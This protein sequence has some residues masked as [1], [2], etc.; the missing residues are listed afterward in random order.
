[1]VL[2]LFTSLFYLITAEK[3]SEI[4]E[5]TLTLALCYELQELDTGFEIYSANENNLE[6]CN[7]FLNPMGY[8]R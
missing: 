1:M 6:E 3:G 8:R 7:S 5:N 4:N 2:L